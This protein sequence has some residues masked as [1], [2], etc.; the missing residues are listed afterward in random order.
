VVINVKGIGRLPLHIVA[1][2]TD[3]KSAYEEFPW[4]VHLIPNADNGLRKESGADTFQV[5]SL[6]EDRFVRVLGHVTDQQL[7]QIVN[8]I[9]LCIGYV[10]R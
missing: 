9:A 8:A 6:S 2:I 10:Q 5:K 3:W 1:P 4:F 7:Y